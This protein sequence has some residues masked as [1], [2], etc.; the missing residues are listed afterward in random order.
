VD[1]VRSCR[2]VRSRGMEGTVYVD[3]KIDVDPLLTTAKAHELADAVEERLQAAF[4]EVV[5]VVVHV[6]PLSR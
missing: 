5:D 3:L 1:G 2:D 4:P 6:E